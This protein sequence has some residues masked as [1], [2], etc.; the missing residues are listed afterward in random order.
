[1]CYTYLG[2]VLTTILLIEMWAMQ[3]CRLKET[4][5]FL[6]M[7]YNVGSNPTSCTKLII[8]SSLSSVGSARLESI[9]FLY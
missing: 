6:K 8:I 2:K 7:G 5:R 3:E 9:G 1:M 4:P